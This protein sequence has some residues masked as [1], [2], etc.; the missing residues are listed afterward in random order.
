MLVVVPRVTHKIESSKYFLRI[1][2]SDNCLLEYLKHAKRR[3]V[4]ENV[5]KTAK[6]VSV[7]NLKLTAF[8]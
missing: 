1:Q 7:C 4:A 5:F 6:V 3:L 8:H 2:L